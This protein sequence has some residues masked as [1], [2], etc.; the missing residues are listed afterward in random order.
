M[1]LSL[2][3]LQPLLPLHPPRTDSSEMGDELSPAF[4]VWHRGRGS[5]VPQM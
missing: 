4:R 5:V 1:S 3:L 2:L